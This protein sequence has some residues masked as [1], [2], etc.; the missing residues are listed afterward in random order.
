MLEMV[1]FIFG[2]FIKTAYGSEGSGR[3]LMHGS[4]ITAWCRGKLPRST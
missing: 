1:F 4:C 3:Y 2:G